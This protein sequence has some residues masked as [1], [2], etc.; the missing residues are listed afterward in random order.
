MN[1][2]RGF[3]MVEM[4]IT[5]AIIGIL[6]SMAGPSYSR[7]MARARQNEAKASLSEL[8]YKEQSFF[9]E[10]NRYT[11]CLWQIGYEPNPGAGR[12]YSSGYYNA[13]NATGGYDG[14]NP[15]PCIMTMA[16][17]TWG[18]GGGRN[19][20]TFIRNAWA[21]SGAAGLAPAG[22]YDAGASPAGQ[23]F[24]GAAWGSVYSQA[25]VLDVWTIT[26]EKVLTNI[27]VGF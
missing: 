18:S 15:A 23:Y 14:I 21:N 10:F 17:P 11:M 12:Y 3:T 7:M 26:N 1:N 5:V 6:S 8:Y 16:D 4:M 20:A 24:R 22:V 2:E 27:Q 13:F 25:A 19:D 9:T